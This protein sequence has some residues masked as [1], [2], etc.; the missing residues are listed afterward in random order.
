MSYSDFKNIEQA[1]S[2]LELTVEDIPHL[3]SA[4]APVEPSERLRQTLDETLD[5]AASIST[6]K[7]RSELIITPILLE[8]RRIFNNQLGYFSGNTFNVDDSKGLT[9]ACDFILS[10]TANQSLITAPVLTIVEAKDNDIRVGLGQCIAQM[11]A[12][13]IFNTRKGKE[14]QVVYGAVSTG[15]NWKFLMLENQLVKIDLTEYFII[16]L[17]KIL[18]ILVEPFRR[19][20]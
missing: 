15:T 2:A 13:Q 4:I 10:A 18:G 16:Q 12:A 17:D 5:L 3:F 8:V 11:V 7:A 20:F 9:G 1:V 14:Q 19:Y 6:E